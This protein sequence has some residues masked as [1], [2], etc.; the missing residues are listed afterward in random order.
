MINSIPEEPL[1]PEQQPENT[2]I[3]QPEIRDQA[4][5]SFQMVL[6]FVAF[7]LMIGSLALLGI[8]RRAPLGL[9]VIFPLLPFGLGIF[10]L[11]RRSNRGPGLWQGFLIGIAIL[12]GLGLLAFGICVTQA[13]F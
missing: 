2:G 7:A 11:I 8:T 13:K 3:T 1:P 10:I 6:G 12:M 5:K 4:P 9:R